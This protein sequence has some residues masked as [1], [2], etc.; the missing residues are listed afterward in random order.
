MNI[1]SVP[2]QINKILILSIFHIFKSF[3]GFF[4]YGVGTRNNF[5]SLYI[6]ILWGQIAVAIAIC[7]KMYMQLELFRLYFTFVVNL[8]IRT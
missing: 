6:F 4:I 2:S 1:L 7:I 5:A 8:S 3:N